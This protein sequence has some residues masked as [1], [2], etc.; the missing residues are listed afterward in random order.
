MTISNSDAASLI[1][2]AISSV[3]LLA[4]IKTH[5][6]SKTLVPTNACQ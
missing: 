4:R 2:E 5:E 1:I 6:T 3:L